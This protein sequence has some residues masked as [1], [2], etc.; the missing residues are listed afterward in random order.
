MLC[1]PAPTV[2]NEYIPTFFSQ[3][4]RFIIIVTQV[5][6]ERKTRRSVFTLGCG[7]WGKGKDPQ[8]HKCADPG[9]QFCILFLTATLEEGGD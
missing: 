5:S 1:L 9:P 6:E 2:G 8:T 3:F 7:R 4:S